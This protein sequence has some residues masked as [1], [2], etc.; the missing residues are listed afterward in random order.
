M[1]NRS[2]RKSLCIWKGD[3]LQKILAPKQA[4]WA[5]GTPPICLQEEAHWILVLSRESV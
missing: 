4:Q 3:D 2:K 5:G 1:G